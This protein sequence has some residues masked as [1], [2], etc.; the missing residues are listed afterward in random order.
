MIITIIGVIVGT[1]LGRILF[2]IFKWLHNLDKCPYCGSELE[3]WDT[4]PNH[5]WCP[6]GCNLK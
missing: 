1:I 6:K 4:N 2:D 3:Q 5:D